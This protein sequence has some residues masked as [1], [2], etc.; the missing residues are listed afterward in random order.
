MSTSH[1]EPGYSKTVLR[2]VVLACTHHPYIHRQFGMGKVDLV[3]ITLKGVIGIRSCVIWL[4]TKEGVQ[5]KRKEG[6]RNHEE[7]LDLESRLN[8]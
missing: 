7:Y 3:V 2:P 6:L 8:E 4:G 1:L 5:K